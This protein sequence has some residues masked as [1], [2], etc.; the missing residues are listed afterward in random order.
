MGSRSRTCTMAWM[1]EEGT[2]RGTSTFKTSG[3]NLREEIGRIEAKTKMLTLEEAGAE[4]RPLEPR[5]TG[6]GAGQSGVVAPIATST[7]A[8]S[9]ILR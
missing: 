9:T 4:D 8:T 6:G 7:V 2:Y 5:G 3:Q 1:N